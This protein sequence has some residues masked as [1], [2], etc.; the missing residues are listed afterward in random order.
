[1]DSDLSGFRVQ[2]LQ[3]SEV[4]TTFS[5]VKTAGIHPVATAKLKKVGLARMALA[6]V[7]LEALKLNK[8]FQSFW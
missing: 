5:K 1:M 8:Q 2:W 4:R 6:R 3:D 7:V